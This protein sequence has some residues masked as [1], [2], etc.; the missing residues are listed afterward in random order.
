MI[1]KQR[2]AWDG[3]LQYGRAELHLW[4][5]ETVPLVSVYV[6]RT[7]VDRDGDTRRDRITGSSE[8]RRSLNT[9]ISHPSFRCKETK[10]SVYVEFI[11]IL[12]I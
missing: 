4:P 5:C 3:V 10:L 9:G 2:R 12:N 1:V 6:D 11:Y 8:H 7:N